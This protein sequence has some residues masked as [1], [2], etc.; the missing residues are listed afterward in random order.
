MSISLEWLVNK[1]K[2]KVYA[3]SH[4]KGVVRGTS[5]VDKDLT[6]V[7]NDI[8]S[9]GTTLDNLNTRVNNIAENG[10]GGGSTSVILGAAT[11]AGDIMIPTEGWEANES[12]EGYHLDI[13]NSAIE[14][15]T[16]PVVALAPDSFDVAME[17]KLK[18]YCRTY[19]GYMR[20]YA[21]SIPSAEIEASLALIG[22]GNTLPVATTATRGTIRVGDGVV[23][24]P[25][26]GTLSVDKN[27]VITQDELVDEAEALADMQNILSQDDD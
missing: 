16:V 22:S 1:A 23:V 20:L 21:E 24:N 25:T 4:A 6:K 10:V 19:T 2:K 11:N 8:I 13:T 26:T 18:P 15:T 9:M 12:G 14:D 27:T 7:E 17:C 5:T 3:I